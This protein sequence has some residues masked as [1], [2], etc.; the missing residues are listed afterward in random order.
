M[1]KLKNSVIYYQKQTTH[2]YFTAALLGMKYGLFAY[3]VLASFLIYDHLTIYVDL[4]CLSSHLLIA[5]IVSGLALMIGITA[6]T[7]R[8][9]YKYLDNKRKRSK[10]FSKLI[11]LKEHI[12][13]EQI[14]DQPNRI[15]S[16][17]RKFI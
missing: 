11:E 4:S 2:A 16:R 13:E 14:K 8:T 7:T 6:Y 12:K 1:K 15:F 5:C 17:Q 9:H 10:T 3:G